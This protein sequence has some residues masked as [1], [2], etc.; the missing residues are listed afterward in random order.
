[1]LKCVKYEVKPTSLVGL[2][3]CKPSDHGVKPWGL[4]ALILQIL[5][6]LNGTIYCFRNLIPKY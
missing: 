5:Q 1:M 4:N 2:V 6:N 3:R